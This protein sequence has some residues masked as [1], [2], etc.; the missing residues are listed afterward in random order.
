[1]VSKSF[2]SRCNKPTTSS[3][4]AYLQI[5]QSNLPTPVSDMLKIKDHTVK[6]VCYHIISIVTWQS[7]V[8]F[9]SFSWFCIWIGTEF[10]LHKRCYTTNTG[11]FWDKIN[12][13]GD[14]TQKTR[15]RA[16]ARNRYHQV[17]SGGK[18]QRSRAKD[19]SQEASGWWSL[20]IS[21]LWRV[22]QNKHWLIQYGYSRIAAPANINHSRVR[23]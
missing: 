21:K 20:H 9:D 19:N 7:K 6:Y 1:M 15:A 23:I 14:R 11:V 2:I 10:V 17:Q 3:W 13:G 5:L 18:R 12:I 16:S 8:I 22:W 4:K